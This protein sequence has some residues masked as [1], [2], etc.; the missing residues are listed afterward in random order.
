MNEQQ[1]P[2]SAGLEGFPEGPGAQSRPLTKPVQQAAQRPTPRWVGWLLISLPSLS[3]VGT[4]LVDP[5]PLFELIAVTVFVVAAWDWH[6]FQD[7]SRTLRVAYLGFACLI[8]GLV[9]LA[10][11]RPPLGPA[12]DD[13][14][15]VVAGFAVAVSLIQLYRSSETVLTLVRGWMYLVALLALGALYQAV[16]PVYAPGAAGP[17]FGWPFRTDAELATAALIGLALMPLGRALEHDRRLRWTYPVAALAA[18]VVVWLTHEG[19][20]VGCAVVVLLIWAATY[21]WGRW[22]ALGA[23]VLAAVVA[24]SPVR[25]VL[26]LSWQDIGLTVFPSWERRLAVLDL[27]LAALRGTWFL[28][29]GPGTGSGLIGRGL[30]CFP[31]E[32]ASQYGFAVLMLCALASLGLLRWCIERVIRTRGQP[33]SSANRAPA[34]W[35]ALY[36][37]GLPIVGLIQSSWL[38]VPLSGLV[39]AT[40]ALIAR[41]AEEPHGRRGAVPLESLTEMAGPQPDAAPTPGPVAP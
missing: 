36:I 11:W 20:A 41:H 9:T 18:L 17:T 27:G 39:I 8:S 37:V 22:L 1:R 4:R 33:W 29:L 13:L 38:D 6:R 15:N 26:A 30:Y 40:A 24:L 10:L 3:L 19:L 34:L 7:R 14:I 23:V 5:F 35:L 16:R 28:G 32:I 21:R 25:R 31:L 2:R 12:I